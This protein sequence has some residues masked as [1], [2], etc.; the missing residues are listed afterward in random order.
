MFYSVL[1][2]GWD[3]EPQWAKN[4]PECFRDL[5]IDQIVTSIAYKRKEFNLSEIFYTHLQDEETILYRQEITRELEDESLRTL[6][7]NFS[8]T[9][10]NL[11]GVM[12]DIRESLVLGGKLRDNY[13]TR[14][15]VMDCADWYTYEV[16]ALA[17][18]LRQ[19]TFASKGL[20]EFSQYIIEYAESDAFKFLGSTVKQLREDFSKIEYTMLI[21]GNT[22]S[23]QKFDDQPNHAT[24]LLKCFEKFRQGE[25]N[26][27]MRALPETPGDLN[28]EIALLDMIA[29][30][31]HEVFHTLDKFCQQHIDFVDG[32]IARFSRE[33][34]FYLGWFESVEETR[35]HGLKFCYPQI[36]VDRN[37]IYAYECYDLALA[38][39]AEAKTITNDFELTSPEKMIVITGP[40]QGG[41]T[42]FARSY[43]QAHY[44]GSLGLS[45]PAREASLA[46]FDNILTHFGREED[47]TQQNG[48][49]RD[50]L[51]RLKALLDQATGNSI[52]I[53]NEIFASTTLSDALL[54]GGYMMDTL[55]KLGAL[56]I[57][58]TFLDELSQHGPDTFSMVGLINEADPTIRTYKILRKNPDGLAYAAHIANKYGLSYE[59][60]SGR[61]SK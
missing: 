23:I 35:K 37:H 21:R 17:A 41:K 57:C 1:T 11:Q 34:Q 56:V 9:I 19:K 10:Y 24:D 44:F 4:A 36:S 30:L 13:L 59:R 3:K 54:L 14:G 60:L 39:S 6:F 58:V 20:S 45:V 15:R 43:A 48:Q 29:G 16:N 46:M 32:A 26:T 18:V 27:Y 31:F 61:I 5:N 25:V 52:I 55:T 2:P 38:K 53:I 22:I 33:I 28:I 42:T 12:A 51:L 40:N 47:V 7:D 50:D 8:R 49:L